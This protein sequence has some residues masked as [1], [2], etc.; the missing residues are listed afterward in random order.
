[1]SSLAFL[2][3]LV[4]SLQEIL[5]FGSVTFL[6]VS[7]LMAIANYKIHR[8]TGAS[9]P[10]TIL[11]V[12]GLSTGTLLILYYE[13]VNQPRQLG[14]IVGLYLLLSLGAWLYARPSSAV[15]GC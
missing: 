15:S 5:E 10:L 12:A 7:L 9:R 13:A 6:L 1:M 2:L 4:G 14:F 11:A 3:V 8:K